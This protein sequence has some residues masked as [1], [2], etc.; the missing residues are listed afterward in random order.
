M[1]GRISFPLVTVQ[2]ICPFSALSTGL[3][4]ANPTLTAILTGR[5]LQQVGR[6]LN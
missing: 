2:E 4:K 5:I 3:A 6:L 1:I